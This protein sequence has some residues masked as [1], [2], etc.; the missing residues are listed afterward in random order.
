[1]VKKQQKEIDRKQDMQ[2]E[3]QEFAKF[4]TEHGVV[5]ERGR[6]MNKITVGQTHFCFDEDGKYTH[7]IWDE[8]GVRQ[9]RL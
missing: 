4:F 6:F 7:L 3:M 1:M 9:D 8:I 5:W 2:G